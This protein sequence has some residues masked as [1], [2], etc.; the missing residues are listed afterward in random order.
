MGERQGG[1]WAILPAMV[2]YDPD[3]P[4]NAKLIYAE[5]A[6]K[7][8]IHGYCYS[9]NKHFALC[10]GLSEDRASA[11]IKQLEKAGYILIDI[12]KHRV[13]SERRRIYLTAKPYDFINRS[14]GE[15]AETESAK[16]PRPIENNNIKINPPISPTGGVGEPGKKKRAPKSVPDWEPE[17]FERFWAAYPRGQDRSSAVKEWDKLKP[18]HKLMFTMSA[19]LNRQKMSEEWLRG[20][21][22]PYACRWLRNR[23]WED[24]DQSVQATEIDTGR[25]DLPCLM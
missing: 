15:N 7:V 21:G 25:S 8:N 3:I 14:I 16:M 13:N 23:R 22:I 20:V 4:A 17:I 19:A 1:Q 9:H 11:L 2:R 10:F 12:D 18:D 6:A 5:I 24:E